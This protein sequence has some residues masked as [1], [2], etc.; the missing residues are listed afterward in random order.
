MLF[1]YR[2]NGNRRQVGSRLIYG[3]F[4]ALKCVAI[5]KNAREGQVGYVYPSRG[6]GL[7]RRDLIW[8]M[9]A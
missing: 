4:L 9:S 2:S 7:L 6:G 8:E 5:E 3:R 1:H